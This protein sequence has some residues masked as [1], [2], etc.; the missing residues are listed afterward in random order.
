M[1]AAPTR[2]QIM[3]SIWSTLLASLLISGCK[4]EYSVDTPE[5]ADPIAKPFEAFSMT[6][7]QTT[8]ERMVIEAMGNAPPD[9]GYDESDW[10]RRGRFRFDAARKT[11]IGERSIAS[12][13]PWNDFNLFP[14]DP[15]G[16]LRYKLKNVKSISV[17]ILAQVNAP[18]GPAFCG[19]MLGFGNA[20]GH[21]VATNAST[22]LSIGGRD[23]SVSPNGN[24]DAR[25]FIRFY[26]VPSDISERIII[27]TPINSYGYPGSYDQF[28]S[29]E[30][31]ESA[32][33]DLD[34]IPAGNNFDQSGVW[35][36][37]HQT[38]TLDRDART[39]TIKVEP[40]DSNF[41]R[42]GWKASHEVVWHFDEAVGTRDPVTNSP[43]G[44][45]DLRHITGPTAMSWEEFYDQPFQFGFSANGAPRN[46]EFSNLAVT[47]RKNSTP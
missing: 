45:L 17:D 36:K 18:G 20:P 6:T 31:N 8:I 7:N 3:I 4:I 21:T 25:D 34:L 13:E 14:A 29:A 40:L 30:W 42:T 12:L 47:L 33:D 28:T 23:W 11:M 39:L 9:Y 24:K 35:I 46:C 1:K 27:D 16:L 10:G 19:L 22:N 41:D 26:Y 38:Y 5:G 2:S 37:T 32:G 44:G 43:R 15:S